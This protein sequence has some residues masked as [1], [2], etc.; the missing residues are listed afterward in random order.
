[1]KRLAR[2]IIIPC[3]TACI[4]VF[5]LV[6]CAMLFTGCG[7]VRVQPVGPSG[8]LAA[9]VTI[10]SSATHTRVKPVSRMTN[11]EKIAYHTAELEAAKDAED[12]TLINYHLRM[13]NVAMAV[14][15]VIE[16]EPHALTHDEQEPGFWRGLLWDWR[17]PTESLK[18]V[19]NLALTLGV[20]T[21]AAGAWDFDDLTGDD[22]SDT[23]NAQARALE[24]SSRRDKN[25]VR[26]D[27]NTF[28]DVPQDR[29][30]YVEGHN[31]SFDFQQDTGK[32]SAEF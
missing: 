13:L 18:S 16:G 22:G 19:G 29:A 5:A 31:N 27:N 30:F 25:E 20:A 32:S 3:G 10:T 26:G 28:K 11:A 8:E 12:D 24:A 7:T 2:E 14:A 15:P 23:A 21:Y 4:W 1:M 17:D 6:A 9:M